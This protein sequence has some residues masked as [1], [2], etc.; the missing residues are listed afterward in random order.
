M[1]K[2]G[3]ASGPFG[4]PFRYIGPYDY[5][6]IKK[7]SIEVAGAWERPVSIFYTGYVYV[8][9]VRPHLPDPIGGISWIGLNYPYTTCY[10][11]FYCGIYGLPHSYEYCNPNKFSRDMA[12]WAY[13]FVANWSGV[14]F[15][16]MIKDIRKKQSNIETRERNQIADIDQKALS[17]YHSNP[18]KARQYLSNYCIN[19]AEQVLKQWWN[20]ADYL[21]QKYT[22][23]YINNPKIAQEVGY[24]KWWREKVGYFNGPTSYKKPSNKKK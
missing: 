10:I 9:Q 2:Q 21:V 1:T 15:S 11:P 6:P 23:G 8:N 24:P 12:W 7:G 14:K 16:Y 4:E 17:L 18:V 3:L 19:N 5:K 20:L 13:N 22:D